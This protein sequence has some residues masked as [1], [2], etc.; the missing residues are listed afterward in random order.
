[1][2]KTINAMPVITATALAVAVAAA[3]GWQGVHV[4]ERIDETPQTAAGQTTAED[5][6]DGGKGDAPALKE[7]A[8][9][10]TPGEKATDAVERAETLPETNL[11]LMLRGVM[12]G[13]T[14]RRD[15][16]LVEGPD[17]GTEVVTDTGA[18]TDEPSVDPPPLASMR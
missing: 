7:L 1:M 11:Q 3:I 8:F 12:A 9:F 14:E 4:A 18:D 15:S 2:E 17:G 10:G 5:S 16:A 13:D 6:S